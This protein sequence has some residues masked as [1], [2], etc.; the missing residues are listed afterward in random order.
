MKTI[1]YRLPKK[2]IIQSFSL[3]SL[4]LFSTACNKTH[5]DVEPEVPIKAEVMI[6]DISAN[7]CLNIQKLAT[8]LQNP[9]FNVPAAIMTTDLKALNNISRAK[10]EYFSYATFYYKLTKANDLNIFTSA[11][12]NDC[13]TIQLLTASN[14]VLT[15]NITD[16]SENQ[17]T[18]ALTDTYQE[19]IPDYEKKVLEERLEP[20]EYVLTYISTHEIKLVV[21]FRSIDPLCDDK[22][23]LKFEITKNISWSESQDGLPKQYQMDPYYLGAVQQALAGAVSTTL[24]TTATTNPP[25]P[26]PV[27]FAWTAAD[28]DPVTPTD[29]TVVITPIEPTEPVRSPIDIISVDEIQKI[30]LTPIRDELKLCS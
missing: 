25:P 8:Q 13:Q 15:Y 14:E 2:Q 28:T 16:H 19:N 1:I 23:Y 18:F 17:I 12:Q 9:Q 26:P 11:H 30:M 29:P 20:Y 6:A 27:F 4:L 3:V 24:D 10:T 21:K 5:S 7:K 22:K